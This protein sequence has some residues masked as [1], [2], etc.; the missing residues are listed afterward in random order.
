MKKF[1]I[2]IEKPNGEI[3]LYKQHEIP[4]ALL[5]RALQIGEIKYFKIS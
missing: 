1:S 5:M 2:E 3:E 4:L